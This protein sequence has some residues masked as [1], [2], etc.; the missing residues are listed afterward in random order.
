MIKKNCTDM[1]AIMNS[2]KIDWNKVDGGRTWFIDVLPS[3]FS[4]M[5]FM[6]RCLKYSMNIINVY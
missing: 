5:S 6:G 3:L 1:Y 2:F 4:E